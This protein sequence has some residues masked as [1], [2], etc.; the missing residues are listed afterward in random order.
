LNAKPPAARRK[1]TRR[2]ELRRTSAQAARRLAKEA[3]EREW[4][5]FL[6]AKFDRTWK[7]MI[8]FRAKVGAVHFRELMEEL[9]STIE[10]I[11]SSDQRGVAEFFVLLGPEHFAAENKNGRR[12]AR[13][14]A[15]SSR[16]FTP[17]DCRPRRRR[18]AGNRT[19]TRSS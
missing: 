3:A 11:G 1:T 10:N 9:S 14:G 7:P 4:R 2:T 13:H 6:T 8:R 19:C 15:E 12:V 16:S 18:F 5:V 17:C